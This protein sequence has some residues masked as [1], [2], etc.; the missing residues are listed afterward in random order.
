MSDEKMC[1]SCGE[2]PAVVHFKEIEDKHV[3]DVGLC[4]R[5]A[6]KRGYSKGV[7]ASPIQDLAEKLVKMAKDVSGSRETDAI[8]CAGCGLL[9]S[10]FAKTGRLGCPTCYETFLGQLK[11]ILRKTHGSVSHVGR[12]PDEDESLRAERRDLRR[13]RGE[14]DRAI[15][16]EAYEDAA[17]LRDEIKALEEA[18]RSRAASEDT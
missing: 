13:K 7:D 15:R 1:D 4:Q 12:R 16:R 18:L 2:A 6:E 9:Y 11:P 5:C 8:R 17:K 3:H 14:L 10:E